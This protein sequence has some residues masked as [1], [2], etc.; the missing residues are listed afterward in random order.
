MGMKMVVFLEP[1]RIRDGG[2]RIEDGSTGRKL[3]DIRS[4]D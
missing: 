1:V 4:G 3:V 2:S